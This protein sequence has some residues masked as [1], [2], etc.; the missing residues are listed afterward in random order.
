MNT[1]EAAARCALGVP[2]D[3]VPV[4]VPG[5]ATAAAAAAAAAGPPSICV[6]P[7]GSPPGASI[8]E[9]RPLALLWCRPQDRLLLG[10][11]DSVDSEAMVSVGEVGDLGTRVIF[12]PLLVPRERDRVDERRVW[13]WV[14]MSGC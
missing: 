6:T 5:G 11:C 10:S 7:C 8:E 1:P 12:L 4:S 2:Q 14:P 3:T 9:G 13:T